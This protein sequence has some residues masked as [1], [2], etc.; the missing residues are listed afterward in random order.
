MIKFKKDIRLIKGK[1]EKTPL[2]KKRK[3]R[4]RVKKL[5]YKGQ[6]YIDLG[7]VK[8]LYKNKGKT[9]RENYSWNKL[10]DHLVEYIVEMIEEETHV[11]PLV[12]YT[13][14]E[15]KFCIDLSRQ[16]RCLYK[17]LEPVVKKWT[18]WLT[19]IFL[20]TKVNENQEGGRHE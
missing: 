5:T 19:K 3:K 7:S 12:I 8:I 6:E 4:V 9:A 1:K 15:R 14:L 2:D 10:Y 20:E 11:K 16:N 17:L 18:D 13:G